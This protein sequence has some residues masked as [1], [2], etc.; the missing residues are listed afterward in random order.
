MPVRGDPLLCRVRREATGAIFPA[1]TALMVSAELLWCVAH[2]D[3]VKNDMTP[4]DAVD[5]TFRQAEAI[6]AKY[7]FA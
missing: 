4:V 5:N 3:V 6:S 2:A 7:T 1:I